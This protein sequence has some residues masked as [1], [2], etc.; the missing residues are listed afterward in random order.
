VD[1]ARG[2]AGAGLGLAIA[3]WIVKEHDAEIFLQSEEA[4]GTVVTV[5]FPTA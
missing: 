3:R 2:R 1:S 4:K 5:V